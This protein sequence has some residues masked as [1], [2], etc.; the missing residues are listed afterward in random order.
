ML[1][2][3]IGTDVARKKCTDF[4]AKVSKNIPVSRVTNVDT[5]DDIRSLTQTGGLFGV[6]RIRVFDGVLS[7]EE[8]EIS[9]ILFSA[10]DS[11]AAAPDTV[12]VL[13]E[14]LLAGPKK[15]LQK[16]AKEFF[17]AEPVK[18]KAERDPFALARA[19]ERSD[20]KNAWI[21]YIKTVA[22]GDAPEKTAGLLFWSAKQMAQRP[23]S[24]A[25]GLAL[26]KELS[27]LPHEA[28][29][30]GEGLEYALERFVLSI[31]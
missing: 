25:R 13:E 22:A 21:E 14:K 10:I 23:T 31:S 27:A 4:I 28:R 2:V 20:K 3:F 17:A 6:D 15:T 8:E 16:Y 12:V 1:Y 30:S 11:L 19:I 9:D 26:A 7:A 5:M 29:R 24:R 18:K